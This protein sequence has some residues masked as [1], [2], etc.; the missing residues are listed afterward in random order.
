MEPYSLVS[1]LIGSVRDIFAVVDSTTAEFQ[2]KTGLSCI[3]GC[4]RCCLSPNV[5]VF[6]SDML[7]LAAY[8]FEVGIEDSIYEKLQSAADSRCI[9]YRP[10]SN[11]P[12]KGLCSAYLFRPSLCRLFGFSAVH[13]RDRASIQLSTCQTIKV[14]QSDAVKKAESLLQEGEEGPHIRDFTLRIELLAPGTVY[15]ES[16]PINRALQLA[17]EKIACVP[18]HELRSPEVE[19]RSAPCHNDM[20]HLIP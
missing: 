17:L 9:L 15:S 19:P 3:S 5:E 6:V 13:S 7:P 2:Q 8:Y 12:S 1:R 20:S 18:S 10:S 4:G 11:D 16:L 14:H